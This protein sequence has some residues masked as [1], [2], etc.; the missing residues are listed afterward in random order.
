MTR[1]EYNS[2]RILVG[3]YNI[4]RQLSQPS[5]QHW[6]LQENIYALALPPLMAQ[7]ISVPI[8]LFILYL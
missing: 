7:H 3:M 2:G 6:V 4:T 5:T 8:L 1:N